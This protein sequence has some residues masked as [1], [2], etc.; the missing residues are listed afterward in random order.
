VSGALV[1]AGQPPAA[2][3][4]AP[5]APPLVLA[6]TYDGIIHPIAA[7]FLS[8]AIA[9]A[10]RSGA[11]L[12]VVTL[13][14]PG[15]LV[16][17]M[18]AINSAIV[19]S[20]VPVAVLVA[21]GGSRAASAGFFI[22]LAADVVAMAPGTHI[23]A[24]HP[25]VGVGERTDETMAKKAASDLAAYARSLA[26]RRGRNVKLAEAAVLESRSFTEREATTAT[27]PLA[28]LVAANLDELLVRLDGREIRRFDGTR[29]TLRTKGARIETVEMSWRERVLSAVAHPQIAYILFSLGMLGLSI[30][31][32]NPGA[33]LPGVVGGLCLLLAFFAFSIL[34]INYVAL[35]L[36][37]FGLLLLALEIKVT[38]YG[39]LAAGGI[40]S[41]LFGSL[42]LIDAPLP[43]VE[44]Q[45]RFVLPIVLAFSAIFL[46]LLW[47]VVEAQRR[48][49]VTGA[50]GMLQARGRALTDIPAGGRGQVLTRGEIWSAVAA[51]PI[52]AGDPVRVVGID[53]LTLTVR[54]DEGE[55]P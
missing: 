30:E 55:R 50:S 37:A 35:L 26:E 39:L 45:L 31:L 48:P 44:L 2:S 12:L 23:G 15:G 24:A 3:S 10:E 27:P 1:A 43:G 16:D 40:A 13:R 41:L 25:V 5:A 22:T 38:S 51:E 8:S 47:L 20:R 11:A 33:I 29:A 19:A 28:D 7:D 6:A 52:A 18:R 34:P 53:G 36:I 54:K 42:M 21:P 4:R 49:A 32:W 17:S 14:T 46:G 9:R